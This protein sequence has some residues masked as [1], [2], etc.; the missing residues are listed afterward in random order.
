MFSAPGSGMK[1]RGWGRETLYS[2]RHADILRWESHLTF[3]LQYF[4]THNFLTCSNSLLLVPLR[5]NSSPQAFL[6]AGPLKMTHDFC[7][8]IYL[9]LHHLRQYWLNE[10]YKV[11][12]T[13]IVSSA[14]TDISLISLLHLNYPPAKLKCILLE[15]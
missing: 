6:H 14:K 10:V 9:Y 11:L 4:Q 7:I 15:F 8:F 1:C 13:M 3:N 5:R 2:R 12:I